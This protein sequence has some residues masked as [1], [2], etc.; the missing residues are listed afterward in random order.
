MLPHINTQQRHQARGGQGVLVCARGDLQLLG[1]S[2]EAQ[3]APAA[4]LH[5]RGL[6]TE[7][8]LEVLQ[9]SAWDVVGCASLKLEQVTY[10]EGAPLLLD[11][12]AHLARGLATATLARG[13]KVCPENTVV[14]VTTSVEL[15]CPACTCVVVKLPCADLVIMERSRSLLHAGHAGNLPHVRTHP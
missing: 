9:T 2:I 15:D 8:L 7:G 11:Q 4:A 5:G 13:C 3:P 1:G 10:L 12:L 6:C 14:D